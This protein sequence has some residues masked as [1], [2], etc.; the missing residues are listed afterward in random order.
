MNTVVCLEC[1][2]NISLPDDLVES[3][4]VTCT[5]CDSIFEIVQMDPPQIEWLYNYDEW[6]EEENDDDDDLFDDD[7]DDDWG[8]E[9][10]DEAWSSLVSKQQRV[11]AYPT[12]PPRKDERPPTVTSN[13]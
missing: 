1:E 7:D 12:R 9:D 13:R 11:Q 6:S 10:E 2:R 5:H 3:D 4:E 8:G